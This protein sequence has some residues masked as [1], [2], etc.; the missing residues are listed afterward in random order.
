MV[1]S[2]IRDGSREGVFEMQLV[3]GSCIWDVK[4]DEIIIARNSLG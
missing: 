4:N 1:Y 2:I 3:G